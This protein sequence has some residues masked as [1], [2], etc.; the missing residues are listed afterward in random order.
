MFKVGIVT[1]LITIFILLFSFKAVS[2]NDN[3]HGISAASGDKCV[4]PLEII[5]AKHHILLNAHGHETVVKGIRTTQHSLKNC[6][7]CH[8]QPTADGSFPEKNSEEHFCSGCHISA[9][10]N[11]TCFDC[12]ASKPLAKTSNASRNK[13]E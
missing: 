10:V 3:D 1:Y 12:H 6:I 8:I 5:R 4:E 7:N 2:H 13:N 11:F 9:A